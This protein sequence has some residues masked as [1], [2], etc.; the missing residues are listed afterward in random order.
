LSRRNSDPLAAAGA[1][2]ALI[3]QAATLES[4]VPF[5]H[6]FNGFRTSHEVNTLELLSDAQIRA[7]IDDGLVHA[8]RARALNPEHPFVRGTAHN[9][10]TFFQAREYA[11]LVEEAGAH[12]VELN[13]FFIPG[14]VAECGRG[15]EQRYVDIL[16][17]VKDA[18]DI[19]QRSRPANRGPGCE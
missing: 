9:P 6:F 16:R 15:V 13:I 17:A 7:M 19:L 10:D 14:D 12:A 18:V 2:A 3:A 1:H 4:R 11:R 5:L 8:H